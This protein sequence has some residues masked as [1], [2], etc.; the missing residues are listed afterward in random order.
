MRQISLKK[1]IDFFRCKNN[2]FFVSYN[3]GFYCYLCQDSRSYIAFI[4]HR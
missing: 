3:Y 4:M 2:I 1:I